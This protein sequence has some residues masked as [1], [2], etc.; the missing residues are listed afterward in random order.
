[1]TIFFFSLVVYYSVWISR[2]SK[3]DQFFLHVTTR[4][5]CVCLCV[6]MCMCTHMCICVFMDVKRTCSLTFAEMKGDTFIHINADWLVRS[7]RVNNVMLIKKDKKQS[8]IM[9]FIKGAISRD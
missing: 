9:E 4:V 8:K 6:H 7:K 3:G 5:Y 1:M 2:L